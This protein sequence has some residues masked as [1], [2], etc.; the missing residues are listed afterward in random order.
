M[1]GQIV[2]MDYAVVGDV[3]KGFA[4]AE[5]VLKTIGTALKVAIEVLRAT[6]F[7]SLGTS[8]ALACYLENIKDKVDHLAKVCNEFSVD[9]AQAIEDHKKGDIQGKRYFGGGAASVK[10]N[11]DH[12]VDTARPLTNNQAG[13]LSTASKAYDPTGRLNSENNNPDMVKAFR[14]GLE[15]ARKAGIDVRVGEAYRDP[16]K[17]DRLYK[18]YKS[19]K[20]KVRAAAAWRSAHNYGLAVDIRVYENGKCLKGKTQAE[21]MKYADAAKYFGSFRQGLSR[22]AGHLEYRGK[23][24]HFVGGRELLRE[25]AAAIAAVTEA[26]G[27]SP[28]GYAEW[29]QQFWTQ[30]KGPQE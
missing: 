12:A 16:E 24:D 19:G 13:A 10:M 30:I 27:K 15:R 29:R 1:A 17:S 5:G 6:A 25:K 23:W 20:S 9:L 4:N 7:F 11:I 8:A 22:D 26:S 3:S 28:T 14:Q 2:Q 18:A 21:S